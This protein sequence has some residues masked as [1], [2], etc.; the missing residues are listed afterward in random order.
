MK[1]IFMYRFIL[2]AVLM[3]FFLFKGSCHNNLILQQDTIKN[4]KDINKPSSG[5][6]IKAKSNPV[7]RKPNIERGKRE[8]GARRIET[9]EKNKNKQKR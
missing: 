1:F 8:Y 2:I 7:Q 4:S 6:I 5:L 3:V 9:F